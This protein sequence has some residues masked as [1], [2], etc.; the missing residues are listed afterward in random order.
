M[1]GVAALCAAVLCAGCVETVTV[2]KLKPDGSG[3]VE[4]TVLMSTAAREQMA[5]MMQSMTKGLG[6]DSGGFDEKELD[7]LKTDELRENAAKLGKG[8]TFV[9]ADTVVTDEAEGYRAVYAF[10]D[11]NEL[12]INQNPG[13]NVLASPPGGKGNAETELVT[14]SFKKGKSSVLRVRRPE[15]EALVDAGAGKDD[16]TSRG[17]SG[18]GK[19]DDVSKE[20]LA[21]VQQMF[22][23]MRVAIVIEVDGAI[24]ETNGTHVDGS[25]VTLMDLDF[26]KLLGAPEQLEEFARANPTTVEAAKRLMKGVPGMKVDLNPELMVRFK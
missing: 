12:R 15:G 17:A 23:G 3:T 16:T 14:F 21:Q 7:M 2:I 4:Q 26:G 10:R 20:M 6:G 13:D 11:I 9:S 24:V 22:E 25:R 18:S 5:M 8:V 1:K 19:D